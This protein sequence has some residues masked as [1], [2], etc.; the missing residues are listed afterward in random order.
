MK[1]HGCADHPYLPKTISADF[2]LG[3]PDVQDPQ[4]LVHL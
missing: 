4:Y 3:I 1:V 2:I